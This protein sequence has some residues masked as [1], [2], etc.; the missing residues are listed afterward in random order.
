VLESALDVLRQRFGVEPR[1]VEAVIGPAVGGCC[2]EVGPEV[3]DAFRVRTGSTTA[4]AWSRGARREHVDLR[5]AARLLLDAAGVPT[6]HVLGPCTA[7]GAGYHSFR[8]DG[9]RT[10]RQLSFV[11]WA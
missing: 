2:Y 6:I 4:T 11:G 5:V 1:A 7:C 9:R 3:R 10:G 8:R